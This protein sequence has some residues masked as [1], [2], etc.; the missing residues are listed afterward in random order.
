V[1]FAAYFIVLH[2][3]EAWFLRRLLMNDL[4]SPGSER[5]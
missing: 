3:M 1:S 5:A 2:A 4:R